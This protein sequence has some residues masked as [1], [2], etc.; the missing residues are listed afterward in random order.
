[1]SHACQLVELVFGARTISPFVISTLLILTRLLSV[2]IKMSVLSTS[3]PHYSQGLGPHRI[4]ESGAYPI[5]RTISPY[6]RDGRYP[7]ERPDLISRNRSYHSCHCGLPIFNQS[8]HLKRSC[9][10]IRPAA[11]QVL[12]IRDG[13]HC[14]C[15]GYNPAIE[16]E[17]RQREILD[18]YGYCSTK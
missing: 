18:R 17:E 16:D 8:D 4:I 11:S 1:M 12:N 14:D 5:S 2:V 7:I 10:L 3:Y 9:H 15:E 13:D 6:D